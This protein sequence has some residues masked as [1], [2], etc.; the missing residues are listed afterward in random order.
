[1]EKFYKVAIILID[2]VLI[3]LAYI[4]AFLLK[5]DGNLPDFNFSPYIQAM[6]FITIAALVYFDVFGL[7]KFFRKSL[8]DTAVSIIFVILLLGI[9]TVAIAYFGQGFSFPRSVLLLAP[10]FQFVL[11]LVWNGFVLMIRKQLTGQGSMM[12]LGNADEIKGIIEK[13]NHALSRTNLNIKHI[14]QPQDMD[15]AVK[16]LKDVDEVL[17]CPG[18]PDDQKMEIISRCIGRKKIVY[19]IPQLFEISLL[20]SRLV[21]FEDVP[22]FMIDRLGLTIEQRF[23]KRIFDIVFSIIGIILTS[24]VMLV[25]AIL[26]KATSKGNV[27][28]T[29]E[30]VTNNNRVFDIYKFRTMYEGAEKDTGPV[31]SGVDDPRVTSVGRFLRKF[32]IDEL[33]QLFN[34]LWGEMSIVGP[35]SERPYFVEQFIKDIPDYKYRNEVKA[36]ITGYA[37]IL[38]NYDTLPEDK[39]RYDLLY[40]KNY[41]LLL[42]IKLILQTLKVVITGNHVTYKSFND[43]LKEQSKLPV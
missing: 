37:Q 16:K 12:V 1:M 33:P 29:Q 9:T 34:V 22:A 38:G 43:S 15:K 3:N 11:L 42:D 28:F 2:L 32:R 25:S 30:R 27:I 23:F 31:L 7:L 5:F 8:Y 21:Q 13:V 6:P 17:I 36:G 19:V 35:R 40:I 41:S 24:P 39:L 10:A 20:H 18:I 4:V 26:I 14:Y